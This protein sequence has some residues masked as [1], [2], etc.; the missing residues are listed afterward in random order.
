MKRFLMLTFCAVACGFSVSANAQDRSLQQGRSLEL[1]GQ[2]KE[3]RQVWEAGI[4]ARNSRVAALNLELAR[5]Y[6]LESDWISAAAY[7][8]LSFKSQRPKK[9]A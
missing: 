4:A 1:Q 9:P 6:S 2:D 8:E 3:T 7:A 5:S